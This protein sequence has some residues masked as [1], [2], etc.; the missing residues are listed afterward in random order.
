MHTKVCEICEYLCLNISLCWC[1][2]ALVK[3]H[4]FVLWTICV[5]LMHESSF[6]V[7]ILMCRRFVV[8][9]EWQLGL[10]FL[11]LKTSRPMHFVLSCIHWNHL[12]SSRSLSSSISLQRLWSMSW[13][14]PWLDPPLQQHA[15]LHPL[16]LHV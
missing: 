11:L 9:F 8:C 1:V 7:F 16:A 15:M 4:V 10:A 2:G 6:C 3:P 12:W 14:L 13:I 5:L